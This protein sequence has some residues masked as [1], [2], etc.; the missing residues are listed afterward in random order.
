[1][2]IDPET[3]AVYAQLAKE[4]RAAGLLFVHLVDHSAMGGPT[5]N[6]DV[7]KGIREAFGGTLILA[8]GFDA[9]K[10]ERALEDKK[11]ELV[12]FGRPFIANPTLVTK[13]KTG[14][15]L[16]APN[17]KLAYSPGPEGYI[18]YPLD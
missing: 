14:A 4:L 12:A 5:P 10:A 18:D 2:V 15:A 9:A 3:A 11:G 13:L 8:G 16:R 6:P 17:F 1:M 7:T